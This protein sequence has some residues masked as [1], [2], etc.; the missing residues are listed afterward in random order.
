MLCKKFCAVVFASLLLILQGCAYFEDKNE[1]A[2]NL[3]QPATTAAP[4]LKPPAIARKQAA[5][6]VPKSTDKTDR[7]EMLRAEER[8]Y[9]APIGQKITWG[10]DQTGSRGELTPV[11]DYY[12]QDGSYCRDLRW[13][14]SQNSQ[15]GSGIRQVCQQSNGTW[16]TAN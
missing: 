11:R 3:S 2:D 10:N 15:T 14:V 8:A 1:P 5:P 13:A 12:A 9:T 6:K 4:A 7:G 16:I